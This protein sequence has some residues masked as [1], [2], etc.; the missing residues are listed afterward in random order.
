M[1]ETPCIVTRDLIRHERDMD[2]AEA[3]DRAIASA[4]EEFTV[5]V[6]PQDAGGWGYV[7]YRNGAVYEA[8]PGP[9]DTDNQ[10]M[11]AGEKTAEAAAKAQVDRDRESA[12]ESSIDV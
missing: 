10:A 8:D 2:A 1:Y 7:V 12:A 6:E 9:W 4:S 3:L 11:R 5:D